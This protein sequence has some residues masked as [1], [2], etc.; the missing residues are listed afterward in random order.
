[1]ALV[2]VGIPFFHDKDTLEMAVRSTINQTFRDWQLILIDDGGHDG[3]LEIARKLASQDSRITVVSDGMN[4]KLPARLNEIIAMSDS[5]YVARMDADD[6]MHPRR[7][8]KE[9]EYLIKYPEVDVVG[10][11]SYSIDGN[12]YILGLK[13]IPRIPHSLKEVFKRSIFIH[14][15][16]M[17]KTSWFK[18]NPYCE[19]TYVERAED[20]ELW[21]RTFKT[22]R[23]A[24]IEEPLYFYREGQSIIKSADNQ[25]KTYN[26][27]LWVLKNYGPKDC[28][29]A[30]LHKLE[31][32]ILCKKL[33]YRYGF[34]TGLLNLL[35][36]FILKKRYTALNNQEMEK[37][38]K[39]LKKSL[40]G[41]SIDN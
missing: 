36:P 32:K 12:G 25:I 35:L 19:E 18:A 28:N 22:S 33:I 1:M 41:C 23:F 14:P 26:S 39:W 27:V 8:E 13:K 40:E 37:G 15:S 17:G 3:T 34:N 7:L 31:F 30:Y 24:L 2:T 21:C 29:S 20:Y 10:A 16:V 9:V 38:K 4:K 6:I 11:D 5:P